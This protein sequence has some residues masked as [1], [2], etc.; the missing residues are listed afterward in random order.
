MPFAKVAIVM[1]SPTFFKSEACVEEL[2]KICTRSKLS[3]NII[4]V[5]VGR[6]AMDD[7]SHFLGTAVEDMMNANLIRTK[8]DGNCI[9]PPDEGLF[10]DNWDANVAA[11]IKRVG[12]LLHK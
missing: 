7:D 3:R 1:F 4:P 5:Y 11:L 9:P 12:E 10:Q 6:V 8:I 2:I